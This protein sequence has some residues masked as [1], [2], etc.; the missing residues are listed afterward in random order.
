MSL[1]K[2]IKIE[3][4]NL[5]QIIV[6]S[7]VLV[8]VISAFKTQLNEFFDSLKDRPITVQMEGSKTSIKLDAP[9]KPDLIAGSVQGPM[10]TASQLN[11]WE[12]VVQHISSIEGFRKG[13]WGE[14]YD[15]L[16]SIQHGEFAVLNYAVNDPSSRYFKD[17]SMLKYLSVASSKVKYLAFYNSRDFVG[18]IKIQSVISGLASG[19]YRF[20]SFGE[21]IKS[22]QW[23]DFPGVITV[24]SS[25]RT[26]PSVRELHDHLTSKNLSEVPLLAGGNL[27]GFLNYESISRELYMQAEGL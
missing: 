24:S 11:D 2:W 10:G 19:D 3:P 20:D 25:F 13:G 4:I 8:I 5:T 23:E 21:K 26:T 16:A 15:R 12:Q 6:T 7:L 18:A 1:G 22:G 9:V 27:V 17:Q 14:L